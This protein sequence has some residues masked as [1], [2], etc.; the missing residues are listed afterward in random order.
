MLSLSVR[1]GKRIKVLSFFSLL[2]HSNRI[3]GVYSPVQGKSYAGLITSN[4][5][6]F[7]LSVLLALIA[8]Q[9]NAAAIK[10]RNNG[11]VIS[12][13]SG[14]YL[15][16]PCFL[17]LHVGSGKRERGRKREREEFYNAEA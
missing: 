13:Y 9:P 11:Y 14:F 2:F 10:S 17:F 1:T 15:A 16:Q 6:D 12:L 8:P 4:D 3:P 7:G 5:P